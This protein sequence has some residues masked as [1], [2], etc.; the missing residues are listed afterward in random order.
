MKKSKF[1][2]RSKAEIRVWLQTEE[3]QA[4]L[5]RKIDEKNEG[6]AERRKRQDMAEMKRRGLHVEC[7]KCLH[8]TGGHCLL[9]LPDGCLDYLEVGTC[10]EL[11]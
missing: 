11:R 8:G 2:K 9:I 7:T 6:K 10:K 1:R 5:Q 4:W 3:A